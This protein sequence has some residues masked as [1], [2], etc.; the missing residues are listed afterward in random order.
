MWIEEWQWDD[1]NLTELAAHGVSPR[2]VEQVAQGSPRFRQNRR[3]RA[4][5]HQMIGPD[6][7]GTIWV[8]CIMQV[9]GHPGLWRAITGW[10][11]RDHEVA[12]YE[13]IVG[14]KR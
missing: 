10:K 3:R 9:G 4:A 5:T 12:W 11:A 7:G 6:A 1:G 2:I 14:G 13:K 8:V